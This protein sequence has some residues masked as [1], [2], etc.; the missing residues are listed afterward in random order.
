MSDL[1][2]PRVTL[3][4]TLG[5]I[6]AVGIQ[7][8]LATGP[9]SGTTVFLIGLQCIPITIPQVRESQIDVEQ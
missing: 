6:I 3:G 7:T 4:V 1:G 5:T 9:V 2:R 8:S